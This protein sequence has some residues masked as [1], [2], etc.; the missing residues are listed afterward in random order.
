MNEQSI[1]LFRKELQNLGY[2]KTVVNNY[3]KQIRT[4][5]NHFKKSFTEISTKDI[6]DYHSH[7]KTIIGTR[8]GK[9]FSESYI[10]SILL[11]IKLYFDYLQRTGV[12]KLNPYQLKIKSPK[13]EERKIFTKEEIQKLYNKSNLQQTIILH[14]CYACGLRRTEAVSLLLKDI[15][16]E[17][18]LLYIRKG[19]G[20]KRRAIPFTKQVKK[21]IE[22][23]IFSTEAEVRHPINEKLLNITGNKM[24]DEFKKLLKKAGLD[25]QKFT[26]HCLR[27][28]IATQLLEQGMELEKV[29]DFLGHEYLGTTQIYTHIRMKN[30]TINRQPTTDNLP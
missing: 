11:S 20:K 10:H 21:D 23:F 17:S 18:N 2:S 5:L 6:L 3:P 7:L 13:S 9:P 26:L 25:N 16:L 27:H 15:D 30:E 12:I 19:K 22:N 24:Y 8:T 28:T 14:L 1:L 4:F 29:R